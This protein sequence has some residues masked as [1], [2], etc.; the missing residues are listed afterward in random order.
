MCRRWPAPVLALSVLQLRLVNEQVL[1]NDRRIMA[2]PDP[3]D[4]LPADEIP[5][6]G[7]VLASAMVATVPDPTAFKSGRNLAAWIGLVPRQNSSGGKEKLG[8]I[9]KQGD[10]YLRSCWWP[11]PW[12]SS[13]TPRGMEPSGHGWCVAGSPASQDRGGRAGQQDG[14]DDLGHDDQRGTI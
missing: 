6:V 8:G 11:G 4:G 2:R 9:T 1:E 13:A 3:R 12:R 7:P 5:G 14:Q 10:R